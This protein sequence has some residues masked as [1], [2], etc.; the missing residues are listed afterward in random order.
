[1]YSKGLCSPELISDV[2]SNSGPSVQKVSVIL[3]ICQTMVVYDQ[4]LR[5]L[6]FAHLEVQEFLIQSLKFE[7]DLV[8]TSIA[9]T[10]LAFLITQDVAGSHLLDDSTM[11]Y[12]IGL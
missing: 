2:L 10:C 4:E 5:I 9:E 12:G 8:H 11:C 3:N 7:E 1:M 6:R